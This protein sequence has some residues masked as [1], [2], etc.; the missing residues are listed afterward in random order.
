MV[1]NH[2]DAVF[3]HHPTTTRGF[4]ETVNWALKHAQYPSQDPKDPEYRRLRYVRY[5]DDFLLGFA[6]PMT[7][8]K[9][10]KDKITTFLGTELKL[11]LSAEKTLITHANTDRARF[12]LPIRSINFLFP[13]FQAAYR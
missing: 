12:L 7:E 11:T 3:D 9:E 5:A 1:T 2:D 8:A 10:I 13:E 4:T 6:G